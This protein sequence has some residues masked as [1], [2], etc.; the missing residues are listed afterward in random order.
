MRRGREGAGEVSCSDVELEA[1]EEKEDAPPAYGQ[2][3]AREMSGS[4]QF[5]AAA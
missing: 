5:F 4:W 3:M 2:V 1:E